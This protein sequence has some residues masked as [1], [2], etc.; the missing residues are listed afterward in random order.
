MTA[1]GLVWRIPDL[2]IAGAR[3]GGVE[4]QRA[5]IVQLVDALA[6]P[7]FPGGTLRWE[8]A[9]LGLREYPVERL[10]ALEGRSARVLA[11]LGSRASSARPLAARLWWIC[12]TPAMALVL[13]S[14]ERLPPLS[15]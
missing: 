5:A 3:L 12:S 8:P 2:P 10:A 4:V 7:E 6:T 9:L 14:T 15:G 13:A 11:E 1:L